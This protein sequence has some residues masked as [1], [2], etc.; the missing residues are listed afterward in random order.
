MKRV[1]VSLA[2]ALTMVCIGLQAQNLS[3]SRIQRQH[4]PTRYQEEHLKLTEANLVITLDSTWRGEQQTAIQL[5][6]DLEQ[7]YPYYPFKSLIQPLARILKNERADPVARRLA[8]LAL[9]EL[10]SDAG[11]AVIKEVSVTC[12][13]TGLKTLCLALQVVSAGPQDIDSTK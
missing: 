8:A 4:G 12:K 6:R 9:D 3:T 7:W 13:D 2:L 5:I 11:D 1:F 10:H